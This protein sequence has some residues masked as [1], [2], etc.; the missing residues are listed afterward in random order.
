MGTTRWA[1]HDGHYTMG[2]TRW[3]LHVPER[4]LKYSYA[5]ILS[6]GRHSQHTHTSMSHNRFPPLL[7]TQRC[8]ELQ[9]AHH[10]LP[11][12]FASRR[13]LAGVRGRYPHGFAGTK[14]Q[15]PHQPP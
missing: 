9:Y 2:T 15:A 14:R 10:V 8:S 3:A 4:R 5:R 13:L 11:S 6:F 7:I 12:A 1:R